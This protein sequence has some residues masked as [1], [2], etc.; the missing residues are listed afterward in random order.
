M[1]G[2]VALVVAGQA[3]GMGWGGAGC[4]GL[5][6]RGFSSSGSR[7]LFKAE[8]APSQRPRLPISL[9]AISVHRHVLLCGDSRLD[10]LCQCPRPD[11]LPARPL[12][13]PV[14]VL[15][16]ATA[17]P[18]VTRGAS[19]GS[20]ADETLR[21]LSVGARRLAMFSWGGCLTALGVQQA[22]LPGAGDS[23]GEKGAWGLRLWLTP[24]SLWHHWRRSS[25][26]EGPGQGPRCEAGGKA[27]PSRGPAVPLD[28]AG[29]GE[30][31]VK[32]VPA[33]PCTEGSEP[34]APS[35]ASI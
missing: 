21:S 7:F 23:E 20:A 3:G 12:P 6:G 10:P 29:P 32:S 16:G 11:G 26:R 9:R 5:T 34:W 22:R 31:A 24:S 13:L 25:R 33:L 14:P 18:P 28:A 15:T 35:V 17:Q 2:E 30:L 4:P 1:E 27:L 19:G 8:V